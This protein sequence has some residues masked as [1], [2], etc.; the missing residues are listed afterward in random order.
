MDAHGH[1]LNLSLG[2]WKLKT[3]R[4]IVG[5]DL[6]ELKLSHTAGCNV[7]YYNYFWEGG[8]PCSLVSKESL[9]NAGDPGLIP[10][11]GRSPG[12]GNGNH[13]SILSW[14]IPWTEEP[15]GL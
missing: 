7:K 4:V 6:E 10:G 2:K 15:G 3:L 8:F 9:C 12:E 13:S 5:E 14:R 1:L 11:L